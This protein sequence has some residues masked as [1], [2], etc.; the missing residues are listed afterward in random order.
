MKQFAFD[1]RQNL[2]NILRNHL[3]IDKNYAV[4]SALILGHKDEL[5]QDILKTYASAG[6]MH[7]LAVSG[8]HVGIIFL[9]LNYVF[10]GL[11]NIKK[12]GRL[13]KAIL[14]IVALWIYAF[15][16]GLSPSVLRAAT[17]FSFIVIGQSTYRSTNIYNTLS[18]S[19][20]L[21]ILINPFIITQVGFQ[22]SYLAVIG[23]VYLQPRLYQ[24]IFRVYIIFINFQA[25]FLFLTCW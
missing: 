10:K 11:E 17:M 22:L 24:T 18:A 2:L 20:F 1:A 5:E 6:A 13:F 7:V 23:I 4:G 16:T 14:L 21:L 15:I 12:Y 8:L 3:K 9:M 25:I 19:A